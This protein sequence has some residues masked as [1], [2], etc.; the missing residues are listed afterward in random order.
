MAQLPK[1]TTFHVA[2][3]FGAPQATTIVTNAAEA[4]VTCAGHGYANGDLVE[5]SSGWGR[6]DKR[7]FE[8]KS[9]TADTF[10]LKRGDTSNTDFFYPG[11][12]VGTVR[13][14]TTLTQ[15]SKVTAAQSNGGEPRN[16]DYNYIESD[17]DYSINDGFAATSYTLTL[18]ADSIGTAGYTALQQ[19]TDVQT[20]TV[21][22]MRTRNGARLFL[23]CTVALNESVTLQSGQINSVTVVF[24][25]NNR[26]TRYGSAE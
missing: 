13:E 8:V 11:E 2:T 15:I 9:A 26:I 1:G 23:P 17:V 25:G 14:V 3:A 22:K 19:L 20:D 6:L 16:V 12:G 18:D 24:N 5:I 21:M 4:V 7:V 10:V